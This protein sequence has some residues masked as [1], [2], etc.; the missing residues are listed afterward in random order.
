MAEYYHIYN[1]RDYPARTIAVFVCGLRA[2][3]RIMQELAGTNHSIDTLLRAR[4]VDSLSWLVWSKTVDGEK[5]RNHPKSILEML[6]NPQPEK[7]CKGFNTAD[8]F[9]RA[10]EEILRG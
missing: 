5:N 3:S 6:T 4:M 8:E 10:R 7:E 9:E 1:Y 2:D